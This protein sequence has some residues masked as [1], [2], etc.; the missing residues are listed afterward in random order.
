MESR[1]MVLLNLVENWLDTVGE[2]ESEM[3]WASTTDIHTLACVKQIVSGKL[4]YNTGSPVW[5]SVMAER[6]EMGGGEEG[7]VQR[8]VDK[9]NDWCTLLYGRNW[10]NTIKQFSPI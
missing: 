6:G 4:L 8:D 7:S 5:C 1:K 9:N 2:G 10:H 3:N